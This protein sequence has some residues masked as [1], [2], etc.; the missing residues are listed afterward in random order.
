MIGAVTF[1]L[2]AVVG[3]LISQILYLRHRLDRAERELYELR[4]DV[5]RSQVCDNALVSKVKSIDAAVKLHL[6]D[7]LRGVYRR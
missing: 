7:V 6:G 5:Y 1:S 4:R 3:V 2:V